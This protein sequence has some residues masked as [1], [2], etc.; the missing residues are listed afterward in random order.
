MD[1]LAV[2][3]HSEQS[4]INAHIRARMFFFCVVHTILSCLSPANLAQ[5]SL[6]YL[7]LPQTDI[8]RGKPNQ[9][10]KIL[11]CSESASS[12]GVPTFFVGS[13]GV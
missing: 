10:D 11:R 9:T 3:K 13:L 12:G 6:R 8:I 4:E 7:T 2:F 5:I 1:Y